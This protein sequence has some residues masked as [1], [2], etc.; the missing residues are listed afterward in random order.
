MAK[1]LSERKFVRSNKVY[2]FG[3]Y[4]LYL[5]AEDNYVF[6]FVV[7]KEGR[8]VVYRSSFD[9]NVPMDSICYSELKE[10]MNSNDV[11]SFSKL[12]E[13]IYSKNVLEIN[14]IP[15]DKNFDLLEYIS[16]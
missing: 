11:D 10:I 9:L 2:N 3:N 15:Y 1:F 14:D 4:E 7:S 13:Y 6:N 8:G 5:D 16:S 12:K